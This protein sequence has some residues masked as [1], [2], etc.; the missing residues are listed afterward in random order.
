VAALIKTILVLENG[1]IP[2]NCWYEKPNPKIPVE[3]WHLKF[4]TTPTLWPAQGLRRASVN[5]FG[6]GGS[7]AHVVLDDALHFL[8]EHNLRGKH[9]TNGSPILDRPRRDSGFE[10]GDGDQ[11]LIRSIVSDI[12]PNGATHHEVPHTNG[13][14]NGMVNGTTNGAPV[15]ETDFG[16]HLIKVKRDLTTI[17][18]SSN[19]VAANG[20]QSAFLA[21]TI[22]QQLR[23]RNPKHFRQRLFVFSSFDEAGIERLASTY[24][25]HLSNKNLGANEGAYL[26]DLAYTLSEKRSSFSWRASIV[27]NSLETLSD[28]L[29][30][31]L[32]AT[33]VTN[34]PRLAFIFTG[35]G[36]Q[37]FAMGRQ[38]LSFKVFNE[39]ICMADDYF[40][41]LGC[42]W[43]LMG[44]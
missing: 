1:I 26:D 31:K 22:Y 19:D 27:A 38:L 8:A 14:V 33:R 13:T 20:Q 42:Q 30:E 34:K 36:A 39:S 44:K 21:N 29:K 7:N 41:S 10:M 28:A 11:A 18:S 24:K 23:P 6:Y 17:Q 2:P 32:I 16:A 25:L 9:R 43:S 35:Q 37:W 3:Q 12:T 40:R 15:T 5:G 4:P